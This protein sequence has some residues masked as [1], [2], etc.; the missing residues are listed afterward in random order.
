VLGRIIEP[1]RLLIGLVAFQILDAL[2][3]A[4][5]NRWAEAELERLRIPVRMRLLLAVVKA[6]S[7]VGLLVGL[8]APALGRLTA[9]A[10]LAY[11]VAALGAHARAKDRPLRYGPAVA[12]LGWSALALRCYRDTPA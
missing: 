4:V 7:A 2:V 12:M 5:P 8:K 3:N 9:R 6:T 1:R 10:L 11:F